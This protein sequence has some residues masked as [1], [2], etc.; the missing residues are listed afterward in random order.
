[1]NVKCERC[2]GPMVPGDDHTMPEGCIKGL[3]RDLE[4]V[5]GV[6]EHL[7]AT[8]GNVV[9][10]VELCHTKGQPDLVFYITTGSKTKDEVLAKLIAAQLKSTYI[11]GSLLRQRK[12]QHESKT[13]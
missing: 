7:T 3:Q 10:R 12:P 6:V 8:T 2:L 11:F 5:Y 1:M 9:A 4:A 13:P